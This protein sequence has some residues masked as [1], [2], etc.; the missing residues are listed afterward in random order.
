MMLLKHIFKTFDRVLL[1]RAGSTSIEFSILAL[2]LFTLFMAIIEFGLITH[3]EG[4]LQ[5][6][7]QTA[8]RVGK[9]SGDSG[10]GIIKQIVTDQMSGWLFD[11]SALTVTP[12]VLGTLSAYDA[13]GN[14]PVGGGF[15][16][17]GELVQYELLYHWKALTPITRL[18]TGQDGVYDIQASVLINNEAF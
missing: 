11:P 12:N 17:G 8:A 6:A 1:C 3:L 7:A 13:T 2:S 10:A 5:N 18:L 15:G 4:L 16:S 9:V 14:A